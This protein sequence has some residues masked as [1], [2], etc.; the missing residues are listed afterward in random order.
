MLFLIVKV[1]YGSLSAN[2]SICYL[3]DSSTDLSNWESTTN[4]ISCINESCL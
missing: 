1:S 3:T 4:L 2:C